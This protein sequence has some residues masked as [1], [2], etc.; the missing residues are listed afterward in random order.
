MLWR[1]CC[2]VRRFHHSILFLFKKMHIYIYINF[3]AEVCRK[4]VDCLPVDSKSSIIICLPS[5]LK[6]YTVQF[7]HSGIFILH[8]MNVDMDKDNVCQ[9]MPFPRVSSFGISTVILVFY[10][11]FFLLHFFNDLDN[12]VNMNKKEQLNVFSGNDGDFDDNIMNTPTEEKRF[13]DH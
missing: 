10:F 4:N 6:L 3:I 1:K 13:A 2:S 12:S 8:A 7:K 11:F 5:D 9:N